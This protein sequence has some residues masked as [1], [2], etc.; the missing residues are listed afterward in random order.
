[1]KLYSAMRGSGY[2]WSLESGLTELEKT[3]V[4]V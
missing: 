4:E 2:R 1:V 3:E